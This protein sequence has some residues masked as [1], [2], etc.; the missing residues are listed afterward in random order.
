[1]IQKLKKLYGKLFCD[2]DAGRM[3]Y[4]FILG[5]LLIAILLIIVIEAVMDYST[6]ES[7]CFSIYVHS[8]RRRRDQIRNASVDDNGNPAHICYGTGKMAHYSTVFNNSNRYRTCIVY[9]YASSNDK[10]SGK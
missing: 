1:M 5:T 3:I 7:G 9:L 10:N 4:N 6:F 2:S 8:S